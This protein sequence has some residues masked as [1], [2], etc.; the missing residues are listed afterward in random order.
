[1]ASGANF[2]RGT[3]LDQDSRFFNK[4]KKLLA[5]MDFPECFKH[6]VDVSKVNKEVMHQWI[7]EK[8]T[9]VLGFE[10]DIVVSTAINLLEPNHPLDPLKPK[11]M[12]MALTGFLEG[13][14]KAFMDELWTLM[15]SAQDNPTGIPQVFLEKKKKEMEAKRASD[16]IEQERIAKRVQSFQQ[17]AAPPAA[18]TKSRRPD[19]DRPRDRDHRPRRRTPSPRRRRDSPPR[20]RDSPPRR[21]ESPPRRRDSS[22]RRRSSPSPRRQRQ[23]SRS[24]DRPSKPSRRS[25]SRDR[26]KT[27]DDDTPRRRRASSSPSDSRRRRGSSVSPK[28]DRADS[29]ADEP[30]EKKQRKSSPSPPIAKD[31]PP[32]KS[33]HQDESPPRKDKDRSSRRRTP[34]PA[35]QERPRHRSGSRERS[36]RDS[37]PRDRRRSRSGDRHRH[38]RSR[39]SFSRSPSKDEF[40]REKRPRRD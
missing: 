17:A 16:K 32:R 21:R 24:P 40:Q 33:R 37:S 35:R 25:S 28:R 38:R 39:R 10:D 19:Y 8:I 2:F 14:A 6:K 22:P 34:S 29:R 27:N 23:P 4:H 7:T 13:D 26:V 20:R 31:T 11:E 36:R 3:T 15:L 5:K 30:S 1:M 12:Q 9:E 18:D